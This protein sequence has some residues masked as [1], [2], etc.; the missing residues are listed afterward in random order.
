MST[1]FKIKNYKIL[2]STYM[3]YCH[4]LASNRG[5]QPKRTVNLLHL[6]YFILS[7]YFTLKFSVK[8]SQRLNINLFYWLSM[9]FLISSVL[10]VVRLEFE[11]C[12]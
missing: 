2:V 10:S 8:K 5:L 6:F 12:S 9:F 4:I 7:L 11:K 3:L 1:L